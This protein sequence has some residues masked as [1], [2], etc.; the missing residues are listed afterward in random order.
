MD[1]SVSATL[2]F[3][4]QDKG[5]DSPLQTPRVSVF[6][7]C[8]FTEAVAQCKGSVI[9][10]VFPFPE[11]IIPLKPDTQ[12]LLMLFINKLLVCKFST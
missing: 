11:D 12:P 8:G 2:A 3:L 7:I 4:L 9:M 10:S 5:I 6:P 1:F